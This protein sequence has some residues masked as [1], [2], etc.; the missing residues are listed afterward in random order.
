MHIL[1]Q[2]ALVRAPSWAK[3]N[4]G[5]ARSINHLPNC[6]YE[7]FLLLPAVLLVPKRK[8]KKKKKLRRDLLGVG[9]FEAAQRDLNQG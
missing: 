7:S 2:E 4:A 5:R 6:D 8:K 3:V 9:G 1:L